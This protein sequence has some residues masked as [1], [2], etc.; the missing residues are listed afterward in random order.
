M[1]ATDGKPEADPE[2]VAHTIC[3]RLLT[4]APKT[5]AQLAA[6]LRRRDVPAP[7]AEA[8]LGRLTDVG[9]I[10]DAAFAT[11]WVSS[12]HRGRGLARRALASELRQRG[13]DPDAIGTAVDALAPDEELETARSLVR[14]RLPLTVGLPLPVRTRRLAG[15]LAR[16]GYPAEV[17]GRAVREALADEGADEEGQAGEE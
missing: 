5:R 12:R 8:V 3:L 14:R 2:S 10:D 6:A 11:A 4:A 16:K 13:V 1:P 15:L 9:L 7:A 17:A